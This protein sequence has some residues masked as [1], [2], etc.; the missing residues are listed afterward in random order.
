MTE[1]TKRLSEYLCTR[2]KKAGITQTQ[3]VLK[4]GF[5]ATTVS[6]VVKGKFP[7]LPTIRVLGAFATVLG[8][9]LSDIKQNAGYI[10]Y[11]ALKQAI[12]DDP[13]LAARARAIYEKG[14]D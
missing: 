3:L 6:K 9:T 14:E 10:D 13:E 2:M 11:S 5:S 4:S 8:V 12:A 1:Q 7:S